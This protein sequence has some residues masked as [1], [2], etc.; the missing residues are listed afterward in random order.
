M[1]WN[2]QQ[3]DWPDFQY[4]SEKLAE[5]ETRFLKESGVILGAYKHITEDE[6]QT[7]IIDMISDEALKTSEIEGEFLNRDSIQ[8]SIRRQ[9]GLQQDV[10]PAGLA[11]QGIAEMMVDLYQTYD[12]PLSHASLHNWHHMLMIDHRHIKVKGG[13]RTHTE[14]MQVISGYVHKPTI[15][16]EAPPS[17]NMESEM[18]A[19]INWF[20]TSTKLPALTRAGLAHL[21]FVSI[22][23]YEDGNGRIARALVEKVL[24]QAIGHPSLIALSQTIE[25]HRTGYYASLEANN[26]GMDIT[27]WL[28]YF[29]ITTLEAQKYSEQLID[30][31]IAKTRFLDALRDQMNERQ[32]KAILRMLKAGIGGFKGGLSADNYMR[33]TGTPRATTTRDLNDLVKKEA[34]FKTGQLKGTRYWLNI[35]MMR[36]VVDK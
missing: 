10:Y 23:P 2:W 15:H 1:K 16:F 9:F 19:F 24:A 35:P 32:K 6:K 25:A 21:Y 17:S 8:S 29:A 31:I 22:H 30:F 33:I 3:K 27:N 7:L 34:L 4:D 20:N 28:T 5:F 14:S 12:A 26:K 36:D 18:E 13:Y 11:E